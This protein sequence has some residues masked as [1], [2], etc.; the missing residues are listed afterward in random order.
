MLSIFNRKNH[1]SF[2]KM[3]LSA[4]KQ[5]Q[6]NT[7][8]STR[9]VVFDTETTGLNTITDKIL[10]I[11]A[12]AIT[13]NTIDVSDSFEVYLKQNEFNP[14]TVEIHGILKVGELIKIEEEKAVEE[15]VKYLGNSIL[16]AHHAAFD[17]EMIN[18]ALKKMNLPKLKNKSIDTGILYKKLEGKKN[19]HFSL[20]KLSEEFNIP[21]H[22]RHTASGDAYITALLFLKILSKL[23]KERTIHYSDLFRGE[24][25]GLI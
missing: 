7:I 23:R 14:E 25:T 6:P 17:I 15:F 9:F 10:S 20:D 24:S 3:Y 22:D 2:W 5:K 19:E 18:T 11:G 8:K 16:V 13:N 12:I 1:P 4:F 21:K